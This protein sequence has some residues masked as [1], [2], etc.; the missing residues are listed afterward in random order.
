MDVMEL[1]EY[2][3]EILETSSK[4]PITGK[5]LINKKEALDVVDKII[6]CLPEE[7][8]KAQWIV[9][10]KQRI[11]GEAT[12]EADEVKRKAMDMLKRQVENH[13]ITIEAVKRAEEIIAAAQKDAKAMRLGARDYAD[14]VLSQL[15]N[16]IELK[17]DEIVDRVKTEVEK[18]VGALDK[19]LLKATD[20]LRDNV[21]ELRSMK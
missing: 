15:Q 8:K 19:E 3:Q 21:K 4:M 16:E 5:V 2:L 7:F 13:D 1:L 12:R 14:E 6:N 20:T 18:F 10:E 9:K 11:L 17:G